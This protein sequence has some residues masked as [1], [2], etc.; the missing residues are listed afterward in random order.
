M[1]TY[2]TTMPSQLGEV[3]IQTTD[4]G[5][6]GIWFDTH[7]TMPDALGK[8]AD[9]HPILTQAVRQ[10]SEY[11]NQDRRAF[12]LPIDTKGTPFQQEVWQALAQIPF[13]ETCSYKQIAQAIGKPK[14]VRAVGA[15]NGKNPVSVVIPCHRVVGAN[16]KLTGYAGGIERKEA[17]LKLEG[18][19]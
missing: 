13:G 17:L 18:I 12:D 11:F 2:F 7:T 19:D 8:R 6:S 15:A 4:K 5:V 14:A 1:M 3:V 9:E 10:L 16:G